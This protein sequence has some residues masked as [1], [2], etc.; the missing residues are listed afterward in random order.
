MRKN[1]T[2]NKFLLT[3]AILAITAI[4]MLAQGDTVS[5]Y[6]DQLNY[7]EASVRA[8]AAYVLG[9]IGDA[10][11]IDSLIPLLND[12]DKYVRAIVAEALGKIKDI[13]VVEA[14][15]TTLQDKERLVRW[16]AANALKQINPDGQYEIARYV[17]DLNDSNSLIRLQA[18]RKLSELV[19]EKARQYQMTRYIKDLADADAQVRASAADALSTIGD[20]KAV[21]PKKRIIIRLRDI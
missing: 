4:A 18:V 19:P 20:A 12:E 11:V 6:I 10:D 1:K 21:T 16:S 8:Y 9:Q 7:K 14:L 15:T 5:E 17:E 3:F 13:K 2:T